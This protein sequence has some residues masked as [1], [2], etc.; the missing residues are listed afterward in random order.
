MT[1]LVIV[2]GGK[3]GEALLAGLL[4]AGKYT[5]DNVVVVEPVKER[6]ADL[7]DRYKVRAIP[8]ADP[9][10][11][12]LF[13]GLLP[14]TILATKPDVIPEAADRAAR[15][16]NCILSIAA[17]VTIAT[18]EQAIPAANQS[19]GDT[20][21]D[22]AVATANPTTSSPFPIIRAMPNTPALV[23][24]GAAAICGNAAAASYMDW[25]DDVLSS[26]GIV[27]RTTEAEL[28]AVTGLSG[29]GPAYFFLVAEALIDAG[30]GV[31]LTRPIATELATQTM[32]GA[33]TLLSEGLNTGTHAAELRANV[34]SPGGTTAAGLK[35]LE[36]E[37]VRAAFANAVEAATQRS[38]QLGKATATP[39][40]PPA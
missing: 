20:A 29:S 17:G 30:V 16:S 35:V 8:S 33:A 12:G 37:R 25:A 21:I 23:G 28:D 32:L 36:Q 24:Q 2:G 15:Y 10:T 26:V 5:A 11:P 34:T 22:H 14:N 13:D 31:G 27:V 38:A 18:I 9:T 40:D 7:T 4:E 39:S 6:C 1:E 19:T 3:M